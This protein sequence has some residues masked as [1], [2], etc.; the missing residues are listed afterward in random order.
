M[1]TETKRLRWTQWRILIADTTVLAMICPFAS[2]I[3][4]RFQVQTVR[5]PFRRTQTRVE[6]VDE[7]REMAEIRT[8][9]MVLFDQT[10]GR[11]DQQILVDQCVDVRTQRQSSVQFSRRAV[12]NRIDVSEIEVMIDLNENQMDR[13]KKRKSDRWLIAV[14]LSNMNRDVRCGVSVQIHMMSKDE[15]RGLDL[16]QVDVHECLRQF[17]SGTVVLFVARADVIVARRSVTD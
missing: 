6:I 17:A 8:E 12:G 16:F 9:T 7:T 5:M 1:R 11:K 4:K 15:S 10:D 2:Q 14:Q 13:F 3:R